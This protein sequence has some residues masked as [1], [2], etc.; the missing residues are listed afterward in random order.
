MQ[1]ARRFDVQ[2]DQPVPGNLVEHVIQERH[3]GIQLLLAGAVN[4]NGDANLRF[5]GVAGNFC[6]A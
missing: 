5:I 3:T 6:N 1:I 2:V 4:I